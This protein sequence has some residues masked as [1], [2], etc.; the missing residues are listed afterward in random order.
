MGVGKGEQGGHGPPWIFTHSLLNLPN[1]KNSSIFSGCGSIFINLPE[2]FSA[3]ALG[4]APEP[5]SVMHLSSTS[6]AQYRC[7][8]ET[9]FEKNIMTFCAI[10]RFS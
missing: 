9:V 3:N 1:F 8:N 5:P 7:L 2:N 4:T 10:Q 6:F